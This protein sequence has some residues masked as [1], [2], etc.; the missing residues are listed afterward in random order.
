MTTILISLVVAVA[1]AIA[2]YIYCAEIKAFLVR[3]RFTLLD[4]VRVASLRF[5]IY[6]TRVLDGSLPKTPLE[7]LNQYKK[8]HGE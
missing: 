5:G 3:V 7:L 8:E 1:A 4:P 6:L 2:T